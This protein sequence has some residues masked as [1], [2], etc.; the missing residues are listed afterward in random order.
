[1]FA[2][3]YQVEDPRGDRAQ[4][5]R[6]ARRSTRTRSSRASPTASP[7]SPT[8][9]A[10]S[11]SPT[12]EQI[13]ELDLAGIGMLPDSR[14]IYPQGELAGA[15]DRHGRH[16]QPGPDR[17]R[18]LRGRAPARHRRRARGRP[19][20]AR[21]RAR[22]RHDRRRR[23]RRRPEADASTPAC[24]PR[25]SAC[26]PS[27][28]ETYQPDGATAIVMD[29]RTSEVLAMANW[30][31]VDPS[32]PGD[33]DARGARATWRPASPTSPARPSRRSRSPAR[34]RRA[35][36]PRRRPSTCRRRSRSPTG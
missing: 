28:G 18:G 9:R 8:S 3:P 5:R 23:D 7:A 19:R 12:A 25:P 36:S 1:M 30:P 31:G 26:S 33:A 32:D 13:R 16:R 4:A 11:T 34:S 21:R 15:G 10:R 24:R 17:A 35:W 22:A 20:R 29:P 27:V 6:G 14:R 2:T